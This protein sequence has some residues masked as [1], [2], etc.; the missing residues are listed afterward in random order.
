[1]VRGL[2]HRDLGAIL[3]AVGR[4]RALPLE[5]LPAVMDREQDRPQVAWV[6]NVLNAVLGDLCVRR[7]LAPNLVATSTDV[8]LLV[9]A[10][11]AGAPLP[12]ESMLARGWR[13]AHMLPELLAVLE[14]RRSLRI[15]DLRADAPFDYGDV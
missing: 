5:Q 13:A 7:E 2:G 10:A 14:G 8:R 6:T 11:L 3:D 15:A 4:A 1:V 9:R 12:E